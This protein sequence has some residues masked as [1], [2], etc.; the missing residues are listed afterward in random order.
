MTIKSTFFLLEIEEG[1]GGAIEIRQ[2]GLGRQSWKGGRSNCTS[3]F[4]WIGRPLD[5]FLYWHR[6]VK[7]YVKQL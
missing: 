7:A 2:D 1:W 5:H 6:R 3:T 4:T